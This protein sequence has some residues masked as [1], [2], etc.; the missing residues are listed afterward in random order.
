[1][2]QAGGLCRTKEDF[3][4]ASPWSWVRQLVI[5]NATVRKR[6]SGAI[7]GENWRSGKKNL[8]IG[9]KKRQKIPEL[10]TT[11]SEWRGGKVGKSKEKCRSEP[12]VKE[13]KLER[14]GRENYTLGKTGTEGPDAKP[15]KAGL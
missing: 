13:K 15:G 12:L 7:G 2:D 10:R 8:A 9:G 11:P 3:A 5:C 14:G 4:R 1:M 6:A